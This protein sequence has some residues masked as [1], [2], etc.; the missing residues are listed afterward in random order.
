MTTLWDFNLKDGRRGGS[1]GGGGGRREQ[2]REKRRQTQ[3]TIF[4]GYSTTPLTVNA[5]S[6]F[7]HLKN[8]LKIIR[9]P[10][11]VSF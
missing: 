1:G 9:K 2:E 5:D 10:L 4:W 3:E 7:C 8:D 6:V 11:R